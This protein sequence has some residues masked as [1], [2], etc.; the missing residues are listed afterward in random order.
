MS[1][2][3]ESSN[4]VNALSLLNSG[5]ETAVSEEVIA[6]TTSSSRFI[7]TLSVVY[8]TS[9]ICKIERKAFAGDFALAGQTNLGSS[10]E[11]NYLFYRFRASEWD[12]AKGE[13]GATEYHIPY[14]KNGVPNISVTSNKAY[15]DLVNKYGP[16]KKIGETVL[17]DGIEF[18]VWIPE[19][20][21]LAVLY[22][23]GALS[24]SVAPIMQAGR[25]R[26]IQLTTR[27]CDSKKNANLSWY[28]LDVVP[29]GRGVKGVSG[30][31]VE[32]T[33]EIPLDIL[34]KTVTLFLQP[35]S[36][37]T[38]DDTGATERDR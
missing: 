38:A 31:A 1:E 22:C 8:G 16:R 29:L 3:V 23:K 27:Y 7:P 35:I 30:L 6:K 4:E 10:I 17:H 14:D 19:Q 9:K 2:I 28:E 33:I 24:K 5:S 12:N 25:G 34:N 26:S 13:F 11:V 36:G 37:V 18:L 15:C 32:Q 20:K 21:V